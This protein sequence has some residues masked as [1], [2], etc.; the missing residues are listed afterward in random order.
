[1]FFFLHV[2]YYLLYKHSLSSR[3]SLCSTDLSA[4]YDLFL[5]GYIKYSV[6][7]PLP[8]WDHDQLKIR[9]TDATNLEIRAMLQQV[10]TK[11]DCWLYV[12]VSCMCRAT[13]QV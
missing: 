10:Y 4:V 11:F 12:G 6:P 5:W 1:M 9:V 7:P 2:P 13:V 8:G 3:L